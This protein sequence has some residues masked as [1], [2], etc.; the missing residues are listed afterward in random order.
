M[1]GADKV[2]EGNRVHMGK[3]R[4]FRAGVYVLVN[5]STT[6]FLLIPLVIFHVCR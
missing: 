5:T 6:L 3:V 1:H 2:K 4:Y